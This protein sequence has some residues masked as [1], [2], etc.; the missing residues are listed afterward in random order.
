MAVSCR[1]PSRLTTS[2]SA[3]TVIASDA[4]ANSTSP[5]L[6]D[7]TD[8]TATVHAPTVGGSHIQKSVK[9][10]CM[11]EARR[12]LSVLI[13]TILKKKGRSKRFMKIIRNGVAAVGLKTALTTLFFQQRISPIPTS[14]DE[15]LN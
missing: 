7:T 15:R 10:R 12:H 11:L 14:A 5:S 13:P 3:I 9:G 8:A 1:L 2:N 6:M 4:L